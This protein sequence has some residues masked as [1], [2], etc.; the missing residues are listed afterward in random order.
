MVRAAEKLR[1]QKSAANIIGVFIE[2]SRFNKGEYKYMNSK[3]I[4]LEVSSDNSFELIKYAI[5]ALEMIYVNGF[6]YKR[7][8]VMLFGLQAA[9]NIQFSLF[10]HIDRYK[11]KQVLKTID[12]INQTHGRDTLRFAVQGH[13]T[14]ISVQE[15]LSPR[16]TTSWDNIPEINSE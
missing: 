15:K 14:K 8:G 13:N 16:Y 10:D 11:H 3:M 5:K 12:L 9:S 1:S 2:T 6:K 4:N 7:A